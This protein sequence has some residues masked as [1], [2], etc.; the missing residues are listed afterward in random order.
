MKLREIREFMQQH[1]ILAA[2][3]WDRDDVIEALRGIGFPN[4]WHLYEQVKSQIM[5]DTVGDPIAREKLLDE[6]LREFKF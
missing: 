6:V 3:D 1:K 5:L 4:R 2:E